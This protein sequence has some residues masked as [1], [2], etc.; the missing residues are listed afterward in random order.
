MAIANPA[1]PGAR[2]MEQGSATVIVPHTAW[3]SILWADAVASGGTAT[4]GPVDAATGI[5][6]TIPGSAATDDPGDA[7]WATF[8]LTGTGG[9]TTGS[10][11]TPHALMVRVIER[12]APG[13][14]SDTYC[15]AGATA[16][17][18]SDATVEAFYGGIQ[19]EGASVTTRSGRI[20]NDNDINTLDATPS[21]SMVQA[22]VIVF[23]KGKNQWSTASSYGLDA[24]GDVT[25]DASVSSGTVAITDTEY[26]GLVAFGRSAATAGDEAV[27]F[28]VQYALLFVD[29]T[30]AQ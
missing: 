22:S 15:I 8:R 11:Q 29:G 2:A 30:W 6:L 26:F 9:I 12:T 5:S 17:A 19:Y 7:I 1:F 4:V 27:I 16:G 25:G 20:V 3:K 14:S 13:T 28:D 18:L 23:D 10:F 24:A 21:G